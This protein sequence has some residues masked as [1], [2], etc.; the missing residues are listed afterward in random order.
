MTFLVALAVAAGVLLLVV[1]LFSYLVLP[2]LIESRLATSLQGR[3]KLEEKPVVEVSSDF[4]P[5][6]LLGRIDRIQLQIDKLKR[7]GL[8]LRDVH[9]DL[10]DVSMLSLLRGDLEREAQEGSLRAEVPKDSINVYLRENTPEFTGEI[11]VLPQG[12]VYR[13]SDALFGLPVNVSLSLRVAGPHTI[14]VIPEEATVGGLSLPSFFP[15][16]LASGGRTLDLGE[17][18]FGT[19]LTSVDPSKEDALVVWAEK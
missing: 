7:E 15:S 12:L 8:L 2:G 6:L 4:P 3:Y 16:S 17:L 9:I 14:E 1:G 11:D 18:P 19:G 10:R 5:R 13:S